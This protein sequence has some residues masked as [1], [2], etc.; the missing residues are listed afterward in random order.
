MREATEVRKASCACTHHRTKTLGFGHRGRK[1]LRPGADRSHSL[2][3]S[4]ANRSHARP[5]N[6]EQDCFALANP[7]LSGVCPCRARQCPE[8]TE[9]TNRQLRLKIA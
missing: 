2:F 4:G 1:A 9:D 6:F 3:L 5:P 8:R 7:E